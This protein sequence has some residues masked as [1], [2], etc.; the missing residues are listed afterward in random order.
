MVWHLV[1]IGINVLFVDRFRPYATAATNLLRLERANAA[2]LFRDAD[3]RLTEGVF[4]ESY[5]AILASIKFFALP[6]LQSDPV[7]HVELQQ[8]AL[9][10]S[11]IFIALRFVT[12]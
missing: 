3:T 1:E 9:G 6:L 10:L 8:R 12:I 2:F 11:G 5:L 4:S 7:I